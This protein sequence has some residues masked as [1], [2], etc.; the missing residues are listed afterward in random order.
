VVEPAALRRFRAA[1]R[2]GVFLDFDG[3]LS[4][5]A[6]RPELAVAAEGVVEALE[7]LASRET[8]VA[9]V[10][11]RRAEE[12]RSLLPVEG[13]H[14]VG[15]YGLEGP[16][17]FP[18]DLRD[19]LVAVAAGVDGVR[20]EE[21]GSSV[22][23]HFRGARDPDAAGDVLEASLRPLVEGRGLRLMAGKRVWE[24]VPPQM[25]GKGAVIAREVRARS[26]SGALYAGD[27]RADLPAFAALD[28]LRAAGV[29]AV[30]VA[31]RSEETPAS[32]LGEADVVVERPS[33]L[34]DLLRSL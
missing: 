34:V 15:H 33:G 30:K 20:V 1:A 9:V 31:V 17:P 16:A 28:E 25:P 5:I 23:V 29:A 27:D 12:V 14:V 8:L 21:K 4:E 3:S 18:A 13:V 24:A 11:G 32:L 22:A 10:S 19:A 7:A 2:R 6:R 26:L